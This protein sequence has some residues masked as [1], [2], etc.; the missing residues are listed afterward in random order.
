MKSNQKAEREIVL[1]PPGCGKT[2]YLLNVVDQEMTKGTKPSR[3]GY[4]SFTR[5][6][7]HEAMDR[8]I[9]KFN[10]T[11]QD[12]PYFK[13]LHALAFQQ[14][15]LSKDRVLGARQFKE[16]GEALGLAFSDYMPFEEGQMPIS[17]KAGDQVLYMVGMARARLITL[18]EQFDTGP[19]LDVDW[20]RVQQ[21][22]EALRDYKRGTGAVDF[23]DMLDHF[24]ENCAPLDIDVAIIDEAQ[25]LSKQQWRMVNHAI[26]KAKRVHIAG[27]DDQAIYRWSGADVD[28]FLSLEGRKRVLDQS[29]RLP[30]DIHALCNRLSGRITRRFPKE[31]KPRDEK[32]AVSYIATLDALDFNQGSYLIL[33]RNRYL[34]NPIEQFVKESAIPYMVGNRSS[35]DQEQVRAIVL[36]E[37][38]R[39]GED[40]HVDDARHVY[41]YIRSGQGVRRGFKALKNFD[42]N[43]VCNMQTLTTYGGLET[44]VIWHDALTAIPAEELEFM[45]AAKRRGEKISRQPRITL[46]TIHGVKGGE[47]D[48]VV[49]LSDMAYRS[50]ADMQRD[51]DDEHRVAYVGAS[52]AR[53]SL[54]IVLPQ[55][56][57]SY[58]YV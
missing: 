20:Y 43:S 3:I 1:G 33:A 56:N 21:F 41:H 46:S 48:H 51:P 34:L 7:T 53:Q 9:A 45:L 12:F 29:Y 18:K 2:T 8:A 30:S 49:L 47:A 36:W 44:D 50:Y 38:L 31:W 4:F 19:D 25:D 42:E 14:L 57:R 22:D 35:I 15:A 27:D 11:R 55:T 28:T 54:T 40:I 6:A 37:K 39:K 52:R 5:K 32:G 24:V 58:D 17:A 13:T 16:I 10:M 23:S 26:S